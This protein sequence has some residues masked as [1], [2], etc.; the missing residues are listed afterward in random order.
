MS[1]LNPFAPNPGAAVKH[2][3]DLTRVLA[4][5][6]RIWDEA[7]AAHAAE[8]LTQAFKT[9]GGTM[10]LR[11]LQA[12]ALVEMG[13][14][15]G[16]FGPI[17]VGGGKTLITLL[18][19][20]MFGDV[21]RPL[22][23]LP[24]ALRQKTRKEQIKLREHWVLPPFVRIESYQTL[25]RVKAAEFLTN[26]QPDLIIADEVHLLKNKD[27]ACTQRVGRYMKANPRTIFVGVSGTVTKRSIK[28]FAHIAHWALGSR[29]PAPTD[30]VTLEEWSRALDVN[31]NDQR[32]LLPGALAKL[33]SDPLQHVR[34][35]Y[36]DRL[37]QTP[38]V[39]ATQEGPLP[40]E[41]KIT[42]HMLDAPAGMSGDWE[43]L[44]EEWATPDDWRCVDAVEVWR[45][46]R[47]L[48]LG[49]FYTWHSKEKFDECLTKTLSKSAN[50]IENI[51]AKIWSACGHT[52]ERDK[53]AK[54]ALALQ[55]KGESMFC[56]AATGLSQKTCSDLLRSMKAD[57]TSAG[58]RMPALVEAVSTWITTTTQA[59]Y[60][61]SYAGH[62]IE[63]WAC[64]VILLRAF[65]LHTS[66]LERP[67][68]EARGPAEWLAARSAWAAECRRVLQGNRRMLDT[69][70]QLK[71]YL[72]DRPGDYPMAA[73]LLGEWRKV[74]DTFTPNVRAEWVSHHA[75]KW[76]D[77]WARKAPGII[78]VDHVHVGLALQAMGW[79]YYAQ[80]GLNA[81]GQAIEDAPTD[82]SIVASIAANGTGRNLQ[83]W[84]R[85]L[86]VSGP[87]NGARWEQ[88]LGRTHR[89]GQEAEQVTVDVLM[90]CAEDVLGF[91]RAVEDC[92]YQ[93][94]MT[95]QATKLCH[96][97]TEDVPTEND[98]TKAH[99][100]SKTK[101]KD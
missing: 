3:K 58:G 37:T 7:S 41:L 26:Y 25:S 73:K 9:P 95:G 75:L 16:M 48:G 89:D 22:L 52:T 55:R 92:S 1:K 29:S 66:I 63:P 100:W 64:L 91:W 72:D 35:A 40:I 24:A 46:A 15:G 12:I 87:P 11:P 47:E 5:P 60:G 31:V 80:Q 23:L 34:V 30:L 54:L 98:L 88:L 44:R 67:T 96:A 70:L 90:G 33:K 17:R 32:K 69:E 59:R 86:I 19:A 8:V 93:E 97:D 81:N 68:R 78:W 85:N 13:R 6:R 50:T 28:D 76:I 45:H 27:A 62:V 71:N 94:Q 18:A 61:V 65:G 82:R 42:G 56:A 83:A 79:D 4:L 20:R 38:G 21:E 43:K 77:R 53:S 84:S 39:V 10:R 57:A 101:S 49:C 74:M 99:Q 51:A 36:R 14:N 2:S